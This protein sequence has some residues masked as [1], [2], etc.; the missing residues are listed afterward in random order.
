MP[1]QVSTVTVIDDSLKLQNITGANGKYDSLFPIPAVITNALNFDTPM[2]TLTMTGN[3]TF[4]ETNKGTG[5]A[6]MLLLDTSS[7]KHTPSFSGNIQWSTGAAPTWSDY[8]HWQIAFQCFNSTQV[9]AVA[10]GFTSTI[11]PE[12]I[13]LDGTSANPALLPE[14]PLPVWNGFNLY[15]VSNRMIF[16]SN[17][18]ISTSD[19]ENGVRSYGKW[20]NITPSKIYYIR[21]TDHPTGLIAQQPLNLHTAS[22]G[23]ALNTW[24]TLSAAREFGRYEESTTYGNYGFRCCALKVEISDDSAGSNILATGYYLMTWEGGA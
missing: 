3:V 7:D 14:F 16:F 8:Q 2:M 19:L 17:G 4:S 21:V 9:R 10:V 1:I 15:R 22:S 24:H 13:S 23:D 20:N 18:D 11:P 6:A 12:V 5:K